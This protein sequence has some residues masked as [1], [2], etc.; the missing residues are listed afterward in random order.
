MIKTIQKIIKKR[1]INIGMATAL[2]DGNLIV[3][4]VQDLLGTELSG[5]TCALTRTNDEALQVTGLLLRNKMTAR[6]I[7][8]NE[9]FN[10]YNLDE[11][12]YFL[13]QPGLA[14]NIVNITDEAWENAK[15]ALAQ[16]Y[17]RST[18][19]ELCR[20]LI[21]DF[22]TANPKMRYKSDLD[23][24]IRESKLEDFYGE[25]GETILVSTIHKAKG[26]EFD[27]VFMM[28]ED[29]DPATDEAKRL[30]Y[31]AMTRA[32]RNLIVHLDSDFL[33][34]LT[35]DNMERV[36]DR[37]NYQPPAEIAIYLGFKDVWLDYFISRQKLVSGLTSGDNLKVDGEGCCNSDGQSV[38][39]FSQQFTTRIDEMKAKG[40]MPKTA[41]VNFIVHWTKEEIGQEVRVILPELLF[42][43]MLPV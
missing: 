34:K 26:K 11:V 43:R 27:N 12:R 2:P 16:R 20:N 39:R 1:N 30:L 36:S 31:V 37:G 8:S 29:F 7:Q 40:Y 35:A 14:G 10:L 21:R 22:E 32:K 24:F 4:F 42:E 3:P 15:R 23:V 33:D 41:R 19:Y 18:K 13:S 25:N 6:L 5:T 38:L 28:L 9:G 17:L